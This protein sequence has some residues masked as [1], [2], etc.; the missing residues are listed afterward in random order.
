MSPLTTISAPAGATLE[1]AAAIVAAIER[2]MRA[3]APTRSQP[4]NGDLPEG[5]QRAALLEG[6]SRTSHDED[7]AWMSPD[8]G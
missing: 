4:P 7:V 3:S 6:T 2:F 1:E 5:W 8:H